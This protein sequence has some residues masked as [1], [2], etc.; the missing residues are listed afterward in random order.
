MLPKFNETKFQNWIEGF[1]LNARR[2]IMTA[3][4][5]VEGWGYNVEFSAAIVGRAVNK[6]NDISEATLNLCATEITEILA[7]S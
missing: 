5:T 7:K 6:Y 3:I 1:N 2:E 4:Y